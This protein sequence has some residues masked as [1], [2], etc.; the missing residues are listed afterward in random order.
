[1]E[2]EERPEGLARWYHHHHKKK[3]KKANAARDGVADGI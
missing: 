3:N 2:A 1:M